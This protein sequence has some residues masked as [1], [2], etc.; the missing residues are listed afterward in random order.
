MTFNEYQELCERTANRY[1]NTRERM[2]NFGLGIGG[3][4]G[5]VQ[6]LIKKH[7]FHQKEIDT[8]RIK[9]ELGDVLWYLTTLASTFNLDLLEVATSNIEKLKERYPDGINW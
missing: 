7:V 4:A 9:E 1:K 5:E 2:L 8:Y 6:E 3:E